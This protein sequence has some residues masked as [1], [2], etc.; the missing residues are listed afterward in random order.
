M[1]ALQY[2]HDPQQPDSDPDNKLRGLLVEGTKVY[3]V[4]RQGLDAQTDVWTTGEAVITHHI[5]VG[6]Q[7]RMGDATDENGEFYIMQEV[8]YVDGVGPVNGILAA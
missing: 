4:E 2:S 1:A 3:A 8:V 6:P 5:Q 7:I